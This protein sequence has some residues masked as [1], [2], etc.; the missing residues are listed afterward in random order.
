VIGALLCVFCLYLQF[1]QPF[2]IESLAN[3]RGDPHGGYGHFIGSVLIIAITMVA[4]VA[5]V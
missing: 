5:C 2:V 1:A 4:C 3:P